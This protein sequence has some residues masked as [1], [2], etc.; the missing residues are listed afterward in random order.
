MGSGLTVGKQAALLIGYHSL[1][2]NRQT[3]KE[4]PALFCCM[5]KETFEL[6]LPFTIVTATIGALVGI[7]VSGHS[8]FYRDLPGT[9]SVVMGLLTGSFVTLVP[10]ATVASTF[11]LLKTAIKQYG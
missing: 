10:P 6:I 11:W 5:K 7:Y 8:F 3:G 9:T 4:N 2:K 1:P